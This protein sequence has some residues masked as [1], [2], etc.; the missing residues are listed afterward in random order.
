MVRKSEEAFEELNQPQHNEVKT[1]LVQQFQD[2]AEEAEKL[3]G[4]DSFASIQDGKLRLKRDDKALIPASV[5]NLQKAIEASM[6]SVRIEQLLMEVD[7]QI[8]FSRHFVPIQQHGSCPKFFTKLLLLRS[9][10]RQPI[11]G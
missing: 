1:C 10:L 7:Q 6:P 4:K 5:T 9:Y 2:S 3:F 11:L 8:G